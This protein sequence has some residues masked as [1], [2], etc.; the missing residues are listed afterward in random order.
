MNKHLIEQ[1]EELF[2]DD[3]TFQAIRKAERERRQFAEEDWGSGPIT[4]EENTLFE[5]DRKILKNAGIEITRPA[6]EQRKI[7]ESS[8]QMSEDE[9]VLAAGEPNWNAGKALSKFEPLTEPLVRR[10]EVISKPKLDLQE[11][12]PGG[13]SDEEILSQGEAHWDAASQI[14]KDQYA[15]PPLEEAQADIEQN[16]WTE[17]RVNDI[18]DQIQDMFSDALLAKESGDEDLYWQIIEDTEDLQIEKLELLDD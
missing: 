9:C 1:A 16:N 7:N 6:K 14:G 4:P 2:K 15:M 13:L 8:Q 3:K 12:N 17:Q 5:N 10:I 18:E 11:D